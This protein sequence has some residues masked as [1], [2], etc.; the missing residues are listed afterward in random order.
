MLICNLKNNVKIGEKIILRP[1]VNNYGTFWHAYINGIQIASLSSKFSQ[2]INQ[3]PQVKGFI[4][5][6]IY[7]H[8]YEES[9]FSDEKNETKYSEKWNQESKFRGYTYLIDFSGYGK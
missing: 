2:S 7:V 6:N 1:T 8:T 4:V 9:L 3:F 5:S